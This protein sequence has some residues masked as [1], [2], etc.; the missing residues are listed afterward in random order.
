MSTN[1]T[2]PGPPSRNTDDTDLDWD[3]LFLEPEPEPPRDH[4]DKER[5]ILCDPN[6]P[7]E[8]C[9]HL[10]ED[11][12]STLDWV[13]L[14]SDRSPGNVPTRTERCWGGLTE[15]EIAAMILGDDVDTPQEDTSDPGAPRG[16]VI[17]FPGKRRA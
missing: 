15:D 13:G 1:D 2:A 17:P 14:Y 5:A 3:S 8:L 10:G 11:D 9:V 4:T 7:L 12:G 6:S 16:Q